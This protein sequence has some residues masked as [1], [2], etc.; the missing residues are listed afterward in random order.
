MLKK[1][2]LLLITPVLISCSDVAPGVSVNDF[3]RE[4]NINTILA[5]S[6]K[7]KIPES[8]VACGETVYVPAYSSIYFKD[9]TRVYNLTITLAIRNI[10]QGQDIYIKEINYYNSGGKPVKKFLDR[11]IKVSPLETFDLVI[12]EDDTSGGIGSNFIVEWVSTAQVKSPLIETVM[13]S[14]RQGVGL[15][16]TCTGRV[17]KKIK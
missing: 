15:S 6:L 7:I 10:N 8:R 3:F 16:F 12:A 17:I 13:M 9:N 5:H 1:S 11:T 4:K 14:T 2:I